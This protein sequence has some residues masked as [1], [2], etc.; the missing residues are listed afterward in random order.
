MIFKVRL[1]TLQNNDETNAHA[2]L[3]SEL[4]QLQLDKIVDFETNSLLVRSMCRWAEEG[5]SVGVLVIFVIL[6]RE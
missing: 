6:K 3:V 2:D 4:H 5:E 1:V